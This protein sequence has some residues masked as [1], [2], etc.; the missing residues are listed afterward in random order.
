[1]T[2]N[3][4]FQEDDGGAGGPPIKLIGFVLVAAALVVFVVQNGQEAPVEF[5]WMDGSQRMWL[6]IVISAVA[7][8]IL[9]RLA[10]WMWARARRNRQ[11]D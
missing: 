8:A 1:M 6:I 5:L 4:E 9:A 11:R 2:R 7:G 10:G 3:E